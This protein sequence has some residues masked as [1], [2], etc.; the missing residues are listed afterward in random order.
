MLGYLLLG[1]IV[2]DFVE[3]KAR[4]KILELSL[5]LDWMRFP[6]KSGLDEK[7]VMEQDP[8]LRLADTDASANRLRSG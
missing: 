4:T 6:N 8:Y 1:Y 5:V 2:L 3:I 7:K